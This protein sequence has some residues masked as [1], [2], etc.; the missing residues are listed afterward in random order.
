[1]M[2]LLFFV[3]LTAA[4]TG[5]AG[6]AHA[7]YLTGELPQ[8]LI[9]LLGKYEPSGEYKGGRRSYFKA[10][11]TQT[12]RH[13]LW[14]DGA[15][16]WLCSTMEKYS[17]GAEA[18][19][20]GARGDTVVP[21]AVSA[22]WQYMDH[23]DG[24]TEW[25]DATQVAC[26]AGAPGRQAMLD[27]VAA[28]TVSL[29]Y[30]LDETVATRSHNFMLRGGDSRAHPPTLFYKRVS[31]PWYT[32][33]AGDRHVYETHE[34]HARALWHA[35]GT[36]YVSRVQDIGHGDFDDPSTIEP[37][38]TECLAEGKPHPG[39]TASYYRVQDDAL[40][41]EDIMAT[42]QYWSNGTAATPPTWLDLPAL[43]TGRAPAHGEAS[44]LLASVAL[45]LRY[46]LTPG[47]RPIEPDWAL[48]R[49]HDAHAVG[50]PLAMLS[51]EVADSRA[52]KASLAQVSDRLE[53]MVEAQAAA[54]QKAAEV[55]AEAAR[56]ADGTANG[57]ADAA[58]SA[59]ERTSA[60]EEDLWLM[61]DW[62][63]AV[64]ALVGRQAGVQAAW[65]RR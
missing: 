49:L 29:F 44:S 50:V 6:A 11:R 62:M 38:D 55:A 4:V 39:F 60:L 22:Y 26:Q 28:P 8:H 20:L 24:Y 18:P 46:E 27:S 61:P 16:M 34:S 1:M 54:A 21:S 23:T 25:K 10:G 42:W 53:A 12:Q 36:W 45:A 19:M 65:W 7:V 30:H 43:R 35:S 15:G 56:E 37:G 2:W 14:Y 40:L 58:D 47:P 48:A 63:K 57:A 3:L 51:K 32:P 17:T 52:S 33:R 64:L 5:A 9:H 13:A 59:Q 31:T 41:P